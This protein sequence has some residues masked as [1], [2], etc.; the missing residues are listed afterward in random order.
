[1]PPSAKIYIA[2][3]HSKLG[4]W[5]PNVVSLHQ[6][7]DES[8]SRSFSFHRGTPLEFKITRGTW[9]TE[10]V[11]VEGIE[12][13]NH[14]LEVER[15]TTIIIE[16]S[17]WRDTFKRATFLSAQRLS[18]KGGNLELLENWKYHAGDNPEWANAAYNDSA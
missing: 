11:N 2:G 16:I 6:Q 13:P 14:V 15:D 3:S 18:N 12:F 9:E 10:S 5:N 8:W 1:L 4:N 17:H 7:S